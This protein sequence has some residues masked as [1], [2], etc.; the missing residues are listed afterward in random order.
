MEPGDLRWTPSQT[1]FADKLGI[2]EEEADET[3][4]WL[5]M[6]IACE[7]VEQGDVHA[8]MDEVK[9]LLRIFSAAHIAAKRNRPRR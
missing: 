4:F 8:F 6:L 5:E 7:K 9:Q 1:D 3:L 2:V